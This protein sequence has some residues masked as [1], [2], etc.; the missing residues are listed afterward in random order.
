MELDELKTAWQTLDRRLAR[1]S[2]I[3]LQLHRDHRLDRMRSS[4][5]PLFWGQVVQV[6]F[7][8]GFVVLAALLWSSQPTDAAVITAGV[9]VHAYGIACILVAGIVLGGLARID[10]AAPVLKIQ[11]RI[12]RVRR[13]YIISGMVAGLPWWF[14]WVPLLIV[15]SALGGVDLY[16]R[17]PSMVWMGLAIGAAGLLATA[18]FHRWSRRPARPRLARAMDDAVTGRSLRRAQT[19]LDELRRFE[20]E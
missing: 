20:Q 7:G 12:A 9:T 8:I 4:L 11:Q 15:L 13:G 19:Q 17:A 16:A 10:H 18:W 1:D 6:L 2:A 14:L 5:R 3:N